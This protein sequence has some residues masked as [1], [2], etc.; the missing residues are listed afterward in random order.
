MTGSTG[1]VVYSS[2]LFEQNNRSVICKKKKG[3]SDF[4]QVKSHLFE[5]YWALQIL[6]VSLATQSRRS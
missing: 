3:E 1:D 6:Y 4:E 5:V 2:N